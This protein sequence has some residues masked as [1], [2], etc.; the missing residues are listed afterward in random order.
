[1]AITQRVTILGGGPVGA[2]LASYLGRRGYHVTLY[3]RRPDLR[4]QDVG[5]GRS[6]NLACSDRGWLALERVGIAETVRRS[7]IPMR[8]RMLHAEDGQ[9]TFLPYGF[10]GQAIYAISRTLLNKHLLDFAARQPQVELHFEQRALSVDFQ[11]HQLRLCDERSGERRTIDVDRL[12]GADGAFSALR[13]SMRRQDRFDYSQHYVSH[14][15]KELA[16]PPG[17]DG[18]FALDPHALHIWPRGGYMLIALPNADRSFTATLFMPFEG[19]RASFAEVADA[20]ALERL[21]A[22][23]FADVPALI[24]NLTEQFFDNPT[25]SLV[26]VRCSP[27]VRDG[28]YALIGDAAHAVVPFYG[29]GMIAGFEDCRVLDECLTEAG[30]DWAQALAAYQSARKPNGDAIA[31]LALDNFIEMRDLVRTP[32]F[33]LRRRIERRLHQLLPQR[34]TPLYSMVTF[35]HLPYAEARRR[36]QLQAAMLD[37]LAAEEG[38]EELLDSEQFMPLA[39]QAVAK[40]ESM[41]SARSK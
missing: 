32:G 18:D 36:G 23:S 28:R 11:R 13:E 27:W 25:S 1:M 9:L 22:Q 4:S 14:G 8:G 16:I 34:F 38:I 29:Q 15:Y 41:S 21:F 2:L 33:Q 31:D 30:D 7:A 37:A 3:E 5:G 10:D 19:A 6:I 26:T 24:P 12:I 35:S 20:A 40:L 39:E 17:P